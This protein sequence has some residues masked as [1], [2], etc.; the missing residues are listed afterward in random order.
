MVYVSAIPKRV[1]TTGRVVLPPR[2]ETANRENDGYPPDILAG[3]SKL[4]VAVV[5]ATYPVR[6]QSWSWTTHRT[7]SYVHFTP[8]S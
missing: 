1:T 5:L 2:A 8:K 6:G 3:T 4:K 7:T